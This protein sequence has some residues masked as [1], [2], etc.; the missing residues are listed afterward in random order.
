MICAKL[1]SKVARAE[2][3]SPSDIGLLFG[4]AGLAGFGVQRL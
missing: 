3:K 1:P 4:L 2:G